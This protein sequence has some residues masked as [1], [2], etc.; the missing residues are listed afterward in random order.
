MKYEWDE[1]KRLTNLQ[2]H[3]VDFIDSISFEW[4]SA[5]IAEDSRQEYGEQRYAAFGFIESRLCCL[6]YTMRNDSARI[7]SLRKANAKERKHYEKTI[8]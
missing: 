7:I 4:D 8:S 6:V 5:V 1:G 2:K 3:G